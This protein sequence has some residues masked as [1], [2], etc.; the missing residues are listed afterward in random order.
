MPVVS[1][2]GMLVDAATH[3]F[4]VGAFNVTNIIQMEAVIEAAVA[5]RAPL[6]IQTSVTPA[7]F[8]RPEVIVAAS[9]INAPKLLMLSGVGPAAGGSVNLRGGDE[10]ID[11]DIT[12]GE[13]DDA[14]ILTLGLR[15]DYDLGFATLT[16]NTGYKDHDYYYSED[17]DGTPLDINAYQQDQDGDRLVRIDA[18]LTGDLERLPHDL[19]CRKLGVILQG[20]GGRQGRDRPEEDGGGQGEEEHEEHVEQAPLGEQPAGDAVGA[21]IF[22]EFGGCGRCQHPDYQK[23]TN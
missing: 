14:D 9:A 20:P 10:D 19:S 18:D 21:H 22:V 6:I 1:A 15:I 2:K 23:Q 8:L 3:G 16:S 11:S 7:K 17:Y 4:A 5:H 13:A 12:H